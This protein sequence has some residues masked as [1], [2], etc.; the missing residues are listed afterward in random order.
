MF[1]KRKI[2]FFVFLVFLAGCSNSIPIATVSI[3]SES[4]EIPIVVEESLHSIHIPSSPSSPSA[5]PPFPIPTIFVP[6]V[7]KLDVI[8]YLENT[9]EGYKTL[10][11]KIINVG[12]AV[13]GFEVS[14]F[15]SGYTTMNQRVVFKFQWSKDKIEVGETV[16]FR[17]LV[18]EPYPV[19]DENQTKIKI[20]N[21]FLY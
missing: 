14:V 17:Y 8:V 16:Y 12:N 6:M 13:V 11:T 3:K 10:T 19:L 21:L 9:S 1:S 5:T 7:K 20:D 4:I 15:A 2:F 18:E